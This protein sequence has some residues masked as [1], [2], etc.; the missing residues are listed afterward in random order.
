MPILGIARVKSFK[1]AVTASVESEHGFGHTAIIH[2]RRLDRITAFAKAIHVNLFVANGSCGA[3]LGYGGEG[4]TAFTIA[5]PTGEGPCTPK[6][7]SRIRRF[8]V[9]NS[10][11]V[12]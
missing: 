12:V 6:T 7:F 9:A 2:S 11:R 5:G 10:L 4:W 1:E 8:V 3:V